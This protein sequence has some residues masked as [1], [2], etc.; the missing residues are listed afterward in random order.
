M[1]LLE[2]THEHMKHPQIVK[3]VES[4]EKSKTTINNNS[5]N[6]S[7]DVSVTSRAF[8]GLLMRTLKWNDRNSFNS[9][10]YFEICTLKRKVC[11]IDIWYI[12]RKCFP[13][14]PISTTILMKPIQRLRYQLGLMV[15]LVTIVIYSFFHCSPKK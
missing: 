4:A 11:S 7:G 14:S 15:F 13:R 10:L 9:W 1:H 12:N 6:T 8:D 3:S 5:D 2:H